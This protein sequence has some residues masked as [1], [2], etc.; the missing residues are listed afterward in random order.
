VQQS[1]KE[2]NLAPSHP[3]L[4]IFDQFKG[5]LTCTDE[6]NIFIAQAASLMYDVIMQAIILYYIY[7]HNK[8]DM[9]VHL[10][11]LLQNIYTMS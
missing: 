7:V 5:Q 4:V 2:Y 10:L 11:N 1:R 3:A 9:Y 8:I 6:K